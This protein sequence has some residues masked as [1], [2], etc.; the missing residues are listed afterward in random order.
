MLTP[1]HFL[2]G[3]SGVALPVPAYGDEKVGRLDRYQH[4]QLMHQHFWD[5]WSREYLHHLQGRQKWNTNVNSSFK[6]GALVLLIEENLPPQQWKRG[7]IAAVHPGKDDVVRVVTVKTATGDYKR[8][9]A[10]IAM[11]PSVETELSTGGE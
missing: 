5:K 2:I 4:V 8:A 6:V 3:R 7:R 1:S 9:V 10:K 11:M